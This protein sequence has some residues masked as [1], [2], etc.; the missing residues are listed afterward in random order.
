MG[1]LPVPRKNVRYSIGWFQDRAETVWLPRCF[2]AGVVCESRA[3]YGWLSMDYDDPVYG[4]GEIVEPVLLDL[5]ETKAMQRLRGVLQHGISG[6]VGVTSPTTRF[7]H[8]VGVMLFV[9][10]LGGALEE[11]IAALVH[12]VSHTAFSH[13]IDY[14]FDQHDSQSY[15]EEQKE[16]Y[17]A[18][19]DLPPVLATYGYDW[20]DFLEEER[21]G[22]LEQPAPALCAD[23]LDYFFR[24]SISLS[25]A[26]AA[27]VRRA[28]EHLVV[29]DGRI[30]VDD[31][32]TVQFLA[33]TF[34]AADDASWSNFA[35][36][37][38]YELTAQ[39]IK[40]GLR[41]GAIAEEDIWGTDAELWARLVGCDD[42]EVQRLV[43]LVSA[44]T[45]FVWDEANPT[46]WVSTK[47]RT[48][49]PDAIV[50][51]VAHRLS[52][53][54]PEFAAYRQAYVERKRGRWPIRVEGMT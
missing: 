32:A 16:V 33:Y 21:Y 17:V 39:V 8:S 4:S 54:D 1:C 37:G 41:A 14:V 5:L 40:A 15:H 9:R 52:A 36:V 12:D 19:T 48:I 27:D 31:L 43:P 10:R 13:V 3:L 29:H 7:E 2:A 44:D 11:Q 28:L 26:T 38:L 49:D 35:E 46:W 51:G 22:L 53:L 18:G 50:D 34:I 24:D 20:T 30:V 47:V 25:L 6:L 23:R 42:A 45:Q